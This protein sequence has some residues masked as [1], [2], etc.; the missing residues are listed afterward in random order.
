MIERMAGQIMLW[1]TI[2]SGSSVSLIVPGGI[3]WPAPP[4]GVIVIVLV[5]GAI[6]AGARPDHGAR[7]ASR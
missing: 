2:R 7:S 5:V 1:G 4:P 3:D 6:L